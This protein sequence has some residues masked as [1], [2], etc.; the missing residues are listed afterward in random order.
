MPTKSD[1]LMPAS[2]TTDIARTPVLLGVA[3]RN[4][5]DG[6]RLA[7][8][9]ARSELVPKNFRNRPEDILVAIQ[10]GIEI[11]LAP[12]QALQSIAVING[13]PGVW[14]DGFL[15]LITASPLYDDHDEYFEVDGQRRDGLVVEDLK[16]DTTAAV[17]TFIRRGKRTPVT[18]RFTVGQAKK[19]QLLGKEGPWQ[20]YPDRMLAMR[21]RSFAGRDAFPDLLRG[22]R[23]AEELQDIPTLDDAPVPTVVRTL[24]ERP[25]SLTPA[26]GPE[27]VTIGP[28]TVAAVALRGTTTETDEPTVTLHDGQVLAVTDED[29]YELAKFIGTDHL[30][31]FTCELRGCDLLTVRAFA[32]AE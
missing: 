9:F 7:Q 20:T 27:T 29:A 12:M 15:A 8:M 26:A 5:E 14:G 30:L 25:A 19:A 1:S 24:S 17:C 22:M 16:K 4:L 6:W 18:R 32:I 13:R 10:L 28:G 11:G 31:R 2:A 23:S 3:P 21:A